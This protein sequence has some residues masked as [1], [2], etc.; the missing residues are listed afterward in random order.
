MFD[1]PVDDLPAAPHRFLCLLRLRLRFVV[2]GYVNVTIQG[3]LEEARDE[4]CHF[5][6]F[7]QL[8]S[9]RRHRFFNRATTAVQEDVL[10]DQTLRLHLLATH[11]RRDFWIGHIGRRRGLG[12]ISVV[13]SGLC[14][15]MVLGVLHP[16]RA[17]HD[18]QAVPIHMFR[19]V[20]AGVRPRD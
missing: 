6:R 1:V 8:H 16:V 14:R 10:E 11:A 12:F 4:F 19:A 9:Y 2:H 18:H 13:Y 5:I 3:P 15:D 7:W 17:A 20:P